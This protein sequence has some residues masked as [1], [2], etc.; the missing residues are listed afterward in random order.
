M[1]KPL[2]TKYAPAKRADKITLMKNHRIL[3]DATDIRNL[4]E[5]IP[6]I[7]VVL[8]PQRQI[9]FA[10]KTL[11]NFLEIKNLN[12]VIGKRPGETI[13]CVHASEE[14]GGC[15]TSESC[16]YCG[17]VNA[18]IE[19]QEKN[20][21]I[22]HE[23]RIISNSNG[24]SNY[25]DLEVIANPFSFKGESYTILTLED[26]SDKKRKS[27]LER[28]F[29]HDLINTAGGIQGYLGVMRLADNRDEVFK[30]LDIAEELSN[31]LIEEILEQKELV[32]AESGTYRIAAKTLNSEHII[33]NVINHLEH[34]RVAL[35][36]TINIDRSSVTFMIETDE[37]LL[38]RV[39]INMIKN[40]LEA[41]KEGNIIK[42]GT[43][44]IRAYGIFWVMNSG[45]M[46]R[47]VQLQIFQRSFSTKGVSRGLGTYSIKLLTE[48]YLK[49]VVHFESSEEKGTIFSIKLP[50][51]YP[52]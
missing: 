38:K 48:E 27:I 33:Q 6:E 28:I 16:E 44:I 34:H 37:T 5:A 46:S 49:G 17:V 3:V 51:K 43:R 40:A 13:N 18:I 42:T 31:D 30:F 2:A 19:S 24:K 25:F 35:N 15:G 47:E 52:E 36:K 20:E 10:N 50:L 8:N 14:P 21:K 29:F 11:R 45:G 9:L 32:A 39:L 7:A 22:I 23:C 26:I 41:T 12:Q 4:L 1:M